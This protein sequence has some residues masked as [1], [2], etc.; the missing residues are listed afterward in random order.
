MTTLTSLNHFAGCRSL[1]RLTGALVL[2]NVGCE[3]M[4]GQRWE[5]LQAIHWVENPTNTSRPGP[6]GELGAYQFR[7]QTWRMHTHQPFSTALDRRCSDDV[8]VRH[9]EWL[10]LRLERAALAPTPYNIALAWNAGINSVL[11]DRAPN[12]SHDYASRVHNLA[13][14]LRDRQ[15]VATVTSKSN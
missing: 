3:L 14:E 2:A 12:P 6:Y 7:L 11:K 15:V 1:L 5:T 9:Y 4:A 8:A 13:M 10:K